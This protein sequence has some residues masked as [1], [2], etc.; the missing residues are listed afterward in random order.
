MTPREKLEII[1]WSCI[2]ITV[3]I[4]FFSFTRSPVE[5]LE[6]FVNWAK[7]LSF[8]RKPRPVEGR[9]Q[10]RDDHGPDV[11]DDPQVA[12]HPSDDS[13]HQDGEKEAA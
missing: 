7:N 8:K 4:L 10:L 3:M 13:A 11:E 9:H 2:G 6:M 12:D 5:L 1:G